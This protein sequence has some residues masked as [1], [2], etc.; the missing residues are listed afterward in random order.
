MDPASRRKG[1]TSIVVGLVTCAASLILRRFELDFLSGVS[2]G[3]S[4]A[5][6]FLGF[7][8]FFRS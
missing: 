5:S 3:I 2:L 6:F 8:A 4:L 1:Q 7:K